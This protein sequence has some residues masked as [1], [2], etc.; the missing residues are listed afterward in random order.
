VTSFLSVNGIPLRDEYDPARPND[1]ATIRRQREEARKEAERE[2]ERQEAM[3]RAEAA[4]VALE[5]A[6]PDEARDLP[7]GAAMDVASG[8][9]DTAALP[10]AVSS[11]EDAYLR[12]GRSSVCIN[13]M[14]DLNGAK[15]D[16]DLV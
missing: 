7:P 11:G 15:T 8:D 1:Y 9:D 10:M 3:R 2:A 4:A 12:R 13:C 14:L 16:S 6:R 5:A